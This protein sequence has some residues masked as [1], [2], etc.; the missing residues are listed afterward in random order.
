LT[1]CEAGDGG[2]GDQPRTIAQMSHTALPAGERVAELLLS[3][4]TLIAEES[5]RRYRAEI[6]GYA[7]IEDPQLIADVQAHTREHHA[8]LGSVLATGEQ[9]TADQLAFVR[10]HA[11]LRARRG[12]RLADFMHAFRIGHLVVWEN[13][14]ELA[15]EDEAGARVALDVVGPLMSYIDHASTH[16]AEAYLEAQQLLVA[17]GDRVRRDLLEDLIAGREPSPGPRQAAALGAGVAP[18]TACVVIVAT[19]VAEPSDELALRLAASRIAKELGGSLPALAVARHDEA[20]VVCALSERDPGDLDGPLECARTQLLREGTP[21]AI[22]ASTASGDP[23]SIGI[24]YRDALAAI[25]RL[26]P[27]GGVL[28]LASV[29]VSDFL[30]MRPDETALRLAGPRVRRFLEEDATRNGTLTN[31]LL[32][33]ADADMNARVAAERLSIHVNTAYQR[34]DRIAERTGLD[35]R[36]FADV[37]ELLAATRLVAAARRAGA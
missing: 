2:C 36:R 16:A 4:S 18:G 14:R 6:P 27:E 29:R 37:Q 12:V 1:G 34:L 10:P 24:A 25:E 19:P 21:L 5:V 9:P 15:D 28:S 35:M 23:G 17:E 20:V 13:I 26:P 30:T 31:T 7:E 8:L 3:R 11:L 33:Y 22:G 32:E